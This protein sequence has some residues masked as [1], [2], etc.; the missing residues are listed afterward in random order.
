MEQMLRIGVSLENKLL[1]QFDKLIADQ[2]Y[3]NRSEAIRDLL[4]QRLTRERLANP[5]TKVV[6]AVFVVYDH[7]QGRLWQKLMELQ[8]SH[9]LKTI[10]SMHIHLDSHNCLE[11]ILLRGKVGEITK[12]GNH[13][14]SLKGVKSGRI[15]LIKTDE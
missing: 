12:L 11:V 6:A 7:H 1:S 14:V 2:G 15:H 10:S 5:K 8:H 3:T 9:L 13:L 4:R